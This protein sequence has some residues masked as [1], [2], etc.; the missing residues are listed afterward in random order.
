MKVIE[1]KS[2]FK[3][4]LKVVVPICFLLLP[5]ATSCSQNEV[6]DLNKNI[7]DLNQDLNDLQP[8]LNSIVNDINSAVD[9]LIQSLDTIEDQPK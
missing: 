7:N 3:N 8:S 6:D 9:N 5:V 2:N 1:M 4:R